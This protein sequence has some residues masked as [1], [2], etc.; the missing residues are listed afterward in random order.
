MKNSRCEVDEGY[1]AVVEGRQPLLPRRD[2]GD[3]LHLLAGKNT[4]DTS[5]F[6]IT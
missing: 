6:T 3:K 1:V 2:V 4:N 5:D